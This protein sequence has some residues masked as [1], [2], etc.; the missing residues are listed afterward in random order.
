MRNED[1]IKQ[2]TIHAKLTN[3]IKKLH[4][5]SLNPDILKLQKLSDS[6]RDYEYLLNVKTFEDFKEKMKSIKGNLG[7]LTIIERIYHNK[8]KILVLK[9]NHRETK[10]KET[11]FEKIL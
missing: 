1:F 4:E 10:E 7:L 11:K 9:N 8:Y 5:D 2:R 3:N 6:I